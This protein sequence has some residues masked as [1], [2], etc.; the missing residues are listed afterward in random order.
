MWEVIIGAIVNYSRD[1]FAGSPQGALPIGPALCVQSPLLSVMEIHMSSL[2]RR[3]GWVV[4]AVAAWTAYVWI[5]RIVNLD[6]VDA[7]SLVVWARIGI[8]LAFA[9]ALLWIGASCLLQRLTTPRLAGYVLLTFGVWMA[10]SWV[11][12]VIERLAAADET[13]AF[14]LVHIGLAF[15]SVGLGTVAASLG[16]RLV[17]G[18]IPDAAAHVSA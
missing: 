2:S 18:L 12:E 3:I 10:I 8:S 4:L 16:R 9:A 11:P 13:V 15:V 5:T 17:R 14:R 7:A 6:A 1:R